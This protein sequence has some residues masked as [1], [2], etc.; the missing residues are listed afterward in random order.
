MSFIYAEIGSIL[1]SIKNFLFFV[2]MTNLVPVH[3]LSS[4]EECANNYVHLYHKQCKNHCNSLL[5]G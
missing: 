2:I 4:I 3:Y 5:I 1:N